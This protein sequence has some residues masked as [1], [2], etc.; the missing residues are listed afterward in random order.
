V[1]LFNWQK[2]WHQWLRRPY[3]LSIGYDQGGRDEP[4]V[5][6]LHGLGRSHDVWSHLVEFAA[7]K[8]L[9]LLAFDLL[10]FGDSPKPN[11]RYDVDDHARAVIAAIKRM[12]PNGPIVLVGHSMGCL[13]AVR[14][15]RLRPDLVGHLILYEM[16][17]YAGLP[18]KRMY[19]L[20][21]KLY[22][23]LYDRIITF[24]PIFSGEGKKR[25]QKIAERIAGYSLEDATWR[26]FVRSLKHTIME[27]QTH[28]DIKQLDMPMDVI[29]GS[30]DRLV[31]RGKTQEIFGEDVKNITAHTI[32]V[33]HSISP[34]ASEFILRRI[35]AAVGQ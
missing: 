33:N 22:Y 3:Q 11:V 6:L 26:P 23:N 21:L 10:G 7:G 12:R 34:M 2:I 19:R 29:Y 24:R 14:V 20:R 35:E 8:Q 9:R 4:T 18:D 15:A 1:K 25:A 32:K 27:Q 28:L 30:R 5:I 16:P 17:L 31:I 13:I